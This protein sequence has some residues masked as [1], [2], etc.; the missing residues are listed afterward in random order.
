[1][2]ERRGRTA[3]RARRV[4][5]LVVVAALVRSAPQSQVRCR[6]QTAS[7]PTMPTA[8]HWTHHHNRGSNTST[9]E[10]SASG[11]GR[12]GC[13]TALTHNVDRLARRYLPGRQPISVCLLALASVLVLVRVV[14][15]R[16]VL[17][18]VLV[19]V[20]GRCRPY[21]RQAHHHAV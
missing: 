18:L 5:P 21:P 8:S 11:S 4:V 14:L 9:M 12:C 6:T 2:V 15:V 1:M 3:R 13:R 19:L 17:V 10:P 7:L 16:V 20:R